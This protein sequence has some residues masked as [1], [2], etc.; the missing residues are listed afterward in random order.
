M[1]EKMTK[2]SSNKTETKTVNTATGDAEK[3][4][5]KKPKGL[6]RVSGVAAVVGLAVAGYFATGPLIKFAIQTGLESTF[7]AE[8]NIESV[9]VS[10]SPFGL[11][12][13][14]LQQTDPANLHANLFQFDQASFTVR[15]LEYFNGMTIIDKMIVQQLQLDVPR[16]VPGEKFETVI[17]TE[18]SEDTIA[19]ND[20][21]SDNGLSIP[22]AESL[23]ADANLQ[24]EI[25]AKQ[26]QQVWQQEKQNLKVSY[27]NLP[28]KSAIKEYERQWQSI[29][30]ENISSLDDLKRLKEKVTKLKQAI[31]ADREKVNI[32]KAQYKTS[33][34]NI[35][36]AYKELEAA[37][38]EDWQM[39]KQ[40]L[41]IDDPNALAISQLLFG[42]K[43]TG[44][45]D[46]G[47]GYYKMAKPY[48]DGYLAKK[49]AV[50]EVPE[51]TVGQAYKFTLEHP[52]PSWIVMDAQITMTLNDES[53]LLAITE[54]TTESYV[55]D[56]AGTY[57]LSQVNS[58]GGKIQADGTFY[59]AKSE[60]F[61]LD[62]K[63][64]MSET[65]ITD[66]QIS[67]DS[68]L[69]LAIQE[70][71]FVGE[72]TYKYQSALDSLHKLN[73][74]KTKFRGEGKSD[75][76]EVLI[77]SLQ[78]VDQF[79]VEVA[80]SGQL[81]SP[82]LSIDSD[83]DNRV[84]SAFKTEFKKE[85]KAVETKA[86]ANLQ[87]QVE[88]QLTSQAPELLKLKELGS[89]LTQWESSLKNKAEAQLDALFTNKKKALEDKLKNQ[90]EEKIDKEKEKLKD[91]F[92]DKLKDFK[93]CE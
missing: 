63:W 83:L 91:K 50:Q 90:A 10:W 76:A 36:V 62:G 92:K 2:R 77:N 57:T 16:E 55:R 48:I 3:A 58:K 4:Q 18:E 1:I 53:W 13:E 69:S 88:T 79:D 12:V 86:K 42:D 61:L 22:S 24:T 6:L 23:L 44:Y 54:L 74:T 32:A 29:E 93:C 21:E 31:N 89:D 73:F 11:T 85:V 82:K 46:Q 81:D 5:P 49:Q 35:D 40:K 64:F 20:T 84:N 39:I 70:S 7:G 52:M 87:K 15:P 68:E 41:P 27:D 28:D 47:L 14:H 30:E 43:I 9:S 34:A 51:D 17:E 72:G 25:K 75:F 37:P 71:A 38:G 60:P 65:E 45:L 33:K 8:A 80:A 26:F 78:N 19:A 56:K 67:G 66:Y 59:A